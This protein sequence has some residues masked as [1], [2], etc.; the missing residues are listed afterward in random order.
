MI[1]IQYIAIF[2]F[3]ASGDSVASS[4]LPI[5]TAQLHS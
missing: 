5:P 4:A 3:F 1:A 2:Q